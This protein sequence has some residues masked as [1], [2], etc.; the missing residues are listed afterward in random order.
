MR[1]DGARTH[2]GPASRDLYLRALALSFYRSV[3]GDEIG[4]EFLALLQDVTDPFIEDE[5][6]EG[7]IESFGHLA[8]LLLREA[9][10]YEGE[11]IGDLW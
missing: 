3:L 2:H 4:E 10:D 1:E 8:A 7:L 9:T 5:E 11:Q 6:T